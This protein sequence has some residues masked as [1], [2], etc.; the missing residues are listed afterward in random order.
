MYRY[1][2]SGLFYRSCT[3]S[4]DYDTTDSYP[5]AMQNTFRSFP[6]DSGGGSY[7]AVKESYSNSIEIIGETG[8]PG[9]KRRR[10]QH[11]GSDVSFKMTYRIAGNFR[12][13]KIFAF[14]AQAHRGRKFF[15]QIILP[16]E[17]ILSR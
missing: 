2:C 9:V 6:T 1:S 5:A 15:R 10:V 11:D 14:F 16:S 4:T 3:D 7:T 17:K 13:E 8:R 12:L